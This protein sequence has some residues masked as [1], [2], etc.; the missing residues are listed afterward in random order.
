MA[1]PTETSAAVT[2]VTR[3]AADVS[4]GM[5]AKDGTSR[6]GHALWPFI[7]IS[8][9]YL[10]FTVT[11]GA[12]RML[13]LLHAY[14]KGFSAME[15]AVMFALY[16]LCGAGTNLAAGV[17]GARW[18][19]QVTLVSGLLM[20][21]VGLALLYGWD[22]T[23][24]KTSAIAYVTFA[25]ALCG[26]AKDLV[27][28]GGKTVT[29]L[30]T[31][32]EKQESLFRLVSSLTGYKNSL[33]GVGYFLGAALLEVS[34]FAAIHVNVALVAL[35]LPFAALGLNPELGRVAKENIALESVFRQKPNINWLSLA[36]FF[37]FGSRDLWFEVPLPFYLRSASGLNW[38]RPAVGAALAGYIIAYGQFQ[39]HSPRLILSP[40]RQSPPNKFVCVLWNALLAVVPAFLAV[41]VFAVGSD[42]AP[43][44]G[45]ARRAKAV[46]LFVGVASFA[47]L[48]AVNSAVHSYL[49]VKYADGDK[50]AMNVGFYYMANAFGRLVGTIVSGALYS[51]VSADEDV[52]IATCFS[53]ATVFVALSGGVAA[54]IDDDEDGLRWGTKLRCMGARSWAEIEAER[55]REKA[56]LAEE[57][58]RKTGGEAT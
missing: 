29:K 13:V 5:D 57:E 49:V 32:E 14:N 31:P 46:V 34:Y 33:K 25:Q 58:A 55:A 28:L 9:T 39:S 56:A 10:L 40:L 38:P 21:V 20:Q 54:Y 17:M 15:V 8:I 2:A 37:L 26:V 6:K 22:D 12:V 36:R 51:Y 16:E 18:G 47:L 42:D 50:V 35:A 23:W 7:I 30:V 41:G 43:S 11:D 19:I 27:K 24:S 1:A 44:D 45:G 3:D 52:G 4:V 48:F 53:A